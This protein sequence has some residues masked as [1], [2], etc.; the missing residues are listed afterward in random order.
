MIK[1]LVHIAAIVLIELG[2]F[3]AYQHADYTLEVWSK[4]YYVWDKT[5]GLLLIL[6]IIYPMNFFKPYWIIMG[7]FFAVRL[8]WEI[9]AI[10]NYEL[11]SNRFKFYLF[12]INL[13]C[14]ITVL[15]KQMTECR[16]LKR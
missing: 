3:V 10:D 8:L 16:K 4:Y 1:A 15:V 12:L 11:A 14:T 9:P 7:V 2:L 6:C 5:V 13:L